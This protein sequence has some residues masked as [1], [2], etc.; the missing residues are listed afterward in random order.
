MV[1]PHHIV[2]LLK[3]KIGKFDKKKGQDR[4]VLASFVSQ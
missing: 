3:L 1:Q 4:E 2:E